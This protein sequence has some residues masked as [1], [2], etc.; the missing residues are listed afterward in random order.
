MRFDLQGDKVNLMQRIPALEDFISEKMS[1]THLPGLS[2]AIVKNGEV[3]YSRGFGFRDLEH[4]SR[5][6]PDT[7]YAIGSVTKSFTALS[8][9]QLVEKGKLGLDEP[10]SKYVPSNFKS[11]GETIK[12]LHLL[13]HAS[14]IPS[15]GYG[16]ALAAFRL[17]I[18][19]KWLPIASYEDFFTF[20]SEADEWSLSRP[21]EKWFYSNEGYA[22]LGYIVEKVSGMSYGNYVKKNILEPLQMNRSFF[23]KEEVEADSEAATPY[24]IT[25]NGEI[26]KSAYVYNLIY[27]DGLCGIKSNVQ[28]LARYITLYLNG[29]K[30]EGRTLLSSK[31]IEEMEKPRIT[32]PVQIFGGEAYCYGL[33][34]IPSFFG[35]KLIWH[36]GSVIVA[37]AYVGFI[38]EKNMGIALLANG[39]G[40]PLSQIG[41]YG[42]ALMLGESPEN[43][44]FI[45]MERSLDLLTGLYETYRGTMRARVASKNGI[46]CIEIPIIGTMP[47]IPED[48]KGNLKKFYS[49]ESGGRLPA[50]FNVEGDKVDL[51]CG[52]GYRMKK[53]GV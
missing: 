1:R 36:S 48:I 24:L 6:T 3:V 14:G 10:I 53:V 40:Y 51:V 21:G 20:M 35:N 9:M 4:G 37:T 34:T 18:D 2:I 23:G 15:L 31:L 30:H 12:V 50:L 27:S 45:N 43:L 25:A 47:L 13:S 7:L 46:L 22:I 42:L 26:K 8:I 28:D 39:R 16:E 49:I 32:E 11:K 17:G 38:P 33:R 41:Q 29:G 52:Y 19:D 5:A 44:P